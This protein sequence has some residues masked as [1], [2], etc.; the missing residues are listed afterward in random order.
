VVI[1]DEIAHKM[2]EAAGSLTR[3]PIFPP[4]YLFSRS[5]LRGEA[6]ERVPSSRGS[7]FAI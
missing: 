1:D 4:I 2:K 3:R 5:F 6:I 7:N